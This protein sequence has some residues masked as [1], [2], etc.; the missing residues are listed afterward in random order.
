MRNFGPVVERIGDDG[1]DGLPKASGVAET[2]RVPV[3]ASDSVDEDEG[4]DGV[5]SV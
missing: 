1:G 3:L 2:V 4:R 5:E